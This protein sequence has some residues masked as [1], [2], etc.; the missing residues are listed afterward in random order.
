MRTSALDPEE[1]G[2]TT[3]T[4]LALLNILEDSN[5]EKARLRETQH[6]VLNM[7]EDLELEKMKIDDANAGLRAEM[8]QRE[9]TERILQL[10]TDDLA[11]SNADLEQFAWVASHDLS[12]P[13]RAISGPISLLAR[14]YEGR[15]DADADEYIGFA[16]DGCQ[17]MQAIIDG[18]LAYSRVGRLEGTLAP[19]DCNLTVRAALTGLASVI[20]ETGADVSVDALPT[21]RA[22]A[23]ELSQVFQNLISNALKFVAPGVRPQV[24]V[25]AERAGDAWRFSVTDNGIGIA[26]EHR[27]RIFGMFKRL[28]GR[29]D[30]PGTGIGLALVKKI[31]ERNGGSIGIDDSPLGGIRFWFTYDREKEV[32]P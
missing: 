9:R 23:T 29:E 10:R 14:R 11:S 1:R 30:Y 32:M 22:E 24:V 15:L 16:V 20:A 27:E 13:L 18:L 21:V 12:E 2:W 4:Q 17:R 28:H 19:V 25:G 6:A 31:L 7:L 26:A 8:N 3:A 5:D